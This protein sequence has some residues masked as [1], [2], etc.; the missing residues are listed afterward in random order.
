MHID[1]GRWRV[2]VDKKATA[3]VYAFLKSGVAPECRCTGCDNYLKVR[4]EHFPPK[5]TDLLERIGADPTKECSVRRVAPLEGSRSLYAGSFALI[6]E[7]KKG[8]VNELVENSKLDVFEMLP[9]GA[10]VAFRRWHKPPKPWQG[11]GKVLR[12]RFLITLPWIGED[13]EE[14][15]DLSNCDGP[16][17]KWE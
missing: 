2:A 7:L 13:P 4:E 10:Q 15:L 1:I 6:G 17:D 5:L 12:L 3:S 14:P 9:D 8:P 11:G 16:A